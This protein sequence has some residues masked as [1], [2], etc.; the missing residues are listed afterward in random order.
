MHQLRRMLSFAAIA[1]AS[2]G[3]AQS[4]LAADAAPTPPAPPPP[5]TTNWTGFYAGGDIGGDFNSA[6]F[7]R[8]TLGLSDISIGS[9]DLKPALSAYAGFNYQVLPWAVLGIEGGKTWLGSSDYRE[10]GSSIDF[11][12]KSKYI[13]TVGARAGVLVR[14]DTMVY[15]KLA[16]AWINVQGFQGFG[17][18]FDKTLSGIQAALGIET[19]LTPNIVLRAE[20]AYTRADEILSLNSDTA[21]YRPT[22]LTFRLGAEYK[23]DAPPG[24]GAQAA[25]L[26][27]PSPATAAA[28]PVWTGFEVGGFGSLN[29]NRMTYNDTAIGELGPYTHLSLG[30]GGFVGGNYEIVQRFVLGLEA[31]ANYDKANFSNA[32]GS[33][34]LLGTFYQFASVN[35]VYAVTAR[36]GWL[37]SPDTLLYAKVGPA[38]VQMSTNNGYWNNIAPNATGSK[39]L[40]GYQAGLG[41]ETFVTPNVSVR[42]EGLYTRVDG[43][44]LLNG[45]IVAREFSLQPAIMAATTG[46]AL[47]F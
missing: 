6:T 17:G 9:I 22:F 19:L 30:G 37:F 2:V 46:V 32:A 36:G 42:V 3:V 11:L 44:V 16:P 41:V 15:G 7:K 47:H 33:G 23:F 35:S 34:G 8:P 10:L 20:A 5:A 45:T 26:Y 40:S 21:R 1:L 24:W 31:S 4:A 13:E 39:T 29:G 14:P 25:G 28:P 27:N 18:T 43:N 38:W 12:E